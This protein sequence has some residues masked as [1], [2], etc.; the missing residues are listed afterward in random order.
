MSTLSVLVNSLMSSLSVLVN[1]LM[2][3]LSVLGNSLMS[4]LSVLVNFLDLICF[5]SV[6]LTKYRPLVCIYSLCY[7]SIPQSYCWLV[8]HI[9]SL[10]FC[11]ILQRKT[12]DFKYRLNCCI[13]CVY[14]H[15]C[16]CCCKVT[17][18][19]LYILLFSSLRSCNIPQRNGCWLIVLGSVAV[20]LKFAFWTTRWYGCPGP[21]STL[22]AWWHNLG[23]GQWNSASVYFMYY[24]EQTPC[25]CPPFYHC[26][27]F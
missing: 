22:V 12:A 2:S 24:L 21:S 20:N 9:S 13:V 19:F 26:Q 18:D 16:V 27:L 11:N 1:S 17:A 3:T 15:L 4:T 8:V 25:L 14:V 10:C 5:S 23:T 7:F 6:P